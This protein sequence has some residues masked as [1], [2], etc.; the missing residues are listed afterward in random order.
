M[1]Q[2]VVDE[3][4]PAGGP[5]L[6]LLLHFLVLGED[7]E[8]QGLLSIVDQVDGLKNSGWSPTVK[9]SIHLVCRADIEDG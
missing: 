7:V 2:G 8:S 1:H 5:G 3:K 4:T 6:E 9:T